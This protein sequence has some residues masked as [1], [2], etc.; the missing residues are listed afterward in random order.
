[1]LPI[2][3]HTTFILTHAWSDDSAGEQISTVLHLM[4]CE[5]LCK[6]VGVWVLLQKS[7]KILYTKLNTLER[8]T[9]LNMLHKDIAISGFHKSWEPRIVAIKN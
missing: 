4:L 8:Y 3:V 6:C 9:K 1:M 5:V 7:E 2:Q